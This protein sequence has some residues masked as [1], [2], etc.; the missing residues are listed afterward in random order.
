MPQTDGSPAILP[1]PLCPCH[2]PSTSKIIIIINLV[3]FVQYKALADGKAFLH[4]LRSVQFKGGG[5]D[6]TV[7]KTY[8]GLLIERSRGRATILQS[9][10]AGT[11]SRNCAVVRTPPP[12]RHLRWCHPPGST[13]VRSGNGRIVAMTGLRPVYITVS[14]LPRMRDRQ[15]KAI[16]NY[17]AQTR[18]G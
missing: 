3:D 6:S 1:R 8:V 10:L 17:P 9:A 11:I 15:W 16:N 2:C 18:K 14:F 7:V 5:V 12:Q 13:G 4:P